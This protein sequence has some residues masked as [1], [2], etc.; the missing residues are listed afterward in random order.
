MNIIYFVY[1]GAAPLLNALPFAL[2]IDY[3]KMTKS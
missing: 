3:L 2:K 1:K